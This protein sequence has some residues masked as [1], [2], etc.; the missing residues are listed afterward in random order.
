[1]LIGNSAE[2]FALLVGLTRI[3]AIAVPVNFLLGAAELRYVLNH[4]EPSAVVFDQEIDGRD[5]VELLKAADLGS[6][7]VRPTLISRTGTIPVDPS[8][9]TLA[10]FLTTDDHASDATLDGIEALPTDDCAIMY[11][12]GSSGPPKGVRLN[13]DALLREAYGTAL[14]RAYIPG[15]ATLTALPVFHLFVL[16]Q[17]V[18]PATFVGGSVTLQRRFDPSEQLNIVGAGHAQD[19]VGVAVMFRRLVD[20]IATFDWSTHPNWALRGIYLGGDAL[21]E[22][23]WQ[24]IRDALRVAEVTS[25]FGMTEVQGA[26]FIAPPES[27]NEVLA[28]TVGWEKKGGCAGISDLGGAQHQWRLA[29]PETGNEVAQ[30]KVGELQ[31]RGPNVSPGYWRVPVDADPSRIDG[32]FHS[33]DLGWIRP[34]GAFVFIGRDSDVFRSG[35]ELVSPAQVEE[36]I[37]ALPDVAAAYVVG[38]SDRRFGQVGFAWVVPAGDVDPDPLVVIDHCRHDL[39]RYKVPKY[40]FAISAG[41]IPL[42][43]S[44]KFLRRALRDRAQERIA[45]ADPSSP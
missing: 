21:P 40:V 5:I 13:S 23:E 31:Y 33:N 19:I 34:D 18:L 22:A 3:G 17:V 1:L 26:S 8:W 16:N 37:S 41:E 24:H 43:A 6:D 14:T 20:E 2:F 29:D 4:C 32:W 12:A 38:V 42:S 45:T 27:S 30:G 36:T 9:I 15:W 39:A 25:G 7:G 44:G 11:T 10:Q 28:H 35:G